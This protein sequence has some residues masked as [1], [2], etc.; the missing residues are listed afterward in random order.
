MNNNTYNNKLIH[1][2]T[3]HGQ[4]QFGTPMDHT[5]SPMGQREKQHPIKHK[6]KYRG[7]HRSASIVRPVLNGARGDTNEVGLRLCLFT[8]T[9]DGG[10]THCCNHFVSRGSDERLVIVGCCALTDSSRTFKV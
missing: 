4:G 6:L 5:P 2:R 3:Y 9:L 7:A 8:P 10:A 1:F